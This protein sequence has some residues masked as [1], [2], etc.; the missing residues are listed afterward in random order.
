MTLDLS[1]D[2]YALLLKYLSRASFLVRE[3]EES[4]FEKLTTQV[5]RQADAFGAADLV[6]ADEVFARSLLED[7]GETIEEFEEEAF[8]ENLA[9]SLTLRDME[10]AGSED[11][12]EYLTRKE[13]YMDEFAESGIHRLKLVL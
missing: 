7:A 10:E 2:H 4:E 12:Q 9:D 1:P 13:R 6:S 11:D 3:E 5:T 8:W